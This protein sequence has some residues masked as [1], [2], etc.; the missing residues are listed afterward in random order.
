MEASKLQTSLT[1]AHWPQWLYQNKELIAGCIFRWLHTQRVVVLL[2]DALRQESLPD[3]AVGLIWPAL[4]AATWGT[5]GAGCA[6][7]VAFESGIFE[8]ALARLRAIGS[9]AEWVSISRGHG[10]AAM[11]LNPVCDMLDVGTAVAQAA[12]S[13]GQTQSM[14]RRIFSKHPCSVM[15][16]A[17]C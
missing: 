11:V 4:Y 3:G 5:T 7:E 6:A 2:L 8:L 15:I 14:R 1:E 10:R 12:V 17:T 9:P 16:V 13:L